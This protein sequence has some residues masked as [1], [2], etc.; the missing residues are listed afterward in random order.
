MSKESRRQFRQDLLK[1]LAGPDNTPVLPVSRYD[2]L[3]TTKKVIFHLAGGRIVENP[4]QPESQSKAS[5]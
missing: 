4:K 5:Q 2:T 1:A 3:S